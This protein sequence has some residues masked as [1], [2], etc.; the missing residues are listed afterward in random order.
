[1]CVYNF[2][3]LSII[4]VLLETLYFELYF[5]GWFTLV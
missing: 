4:Q 3:E 2:E 5:G 1:M